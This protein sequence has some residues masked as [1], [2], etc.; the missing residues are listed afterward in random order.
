MKRRQN[1][2]FYT[3]KV[4][5]SDICRGGGNFNNLKNAADEARALTARENKTTT[6]QGHCVPMPFLASP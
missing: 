5:F 6:A 2:E 3:Q 1:C 4:P